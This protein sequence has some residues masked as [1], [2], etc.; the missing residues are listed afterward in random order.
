M[1]R[2]FVQDDMEAVLSIWLDA[3]I[4]A[5]HFIE[6]AY[7]Q[8]KVQVMREVYLPASETF[9]FER[10]DGVIGFYSLYGDH[11]AALFVEPQAQGKGIGSALLSDAKK[12]RAALQLTVYQENPPSVLFYQH[13]GFEIQQAQQDEHTGHAEWLM[14][15]AHR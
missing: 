8:S 11:L 9:V 1:I 5:H 14:T 12:R 7:W 10:E 15:Y 4:E 3:S 6:A 13:Q 2:T